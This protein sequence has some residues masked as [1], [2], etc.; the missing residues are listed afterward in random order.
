MSRTLDELEAIA[1]EELDRVEA[2][3]FEELDRALRAR[4][5]SASRPAGDTEAHWSALAAEWMGRIVEI[6]RLRAEL[7][8][9]Q[10]A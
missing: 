9:D 6:R 4:S 7:A 5:T 1:F 8:G 3:A 2:I 10:G